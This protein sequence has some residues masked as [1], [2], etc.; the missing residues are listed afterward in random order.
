MRVPAAELRVQEPGLDGELR[1]V[2]RVDEVLELVRPLVEQDELADQV[3]RRRGAGDAGTL[4]VLRRQ[5]HEVAQRR[6]QV[7]AHDGGQVPQLLVARAPGRDVAEQ[8]AQHVVDVAHCRH[9]AD[10]QAAAV[11]VRLA[12]DVGQLGLQLLRLR[13]DIRLGR[14]RAGRLSRR[15]GFGDGRTPSEEHA[16]LLPHGWGLFGDNASTTTRSGRGATDQPSVARARSR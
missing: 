6:R 15:W 16:G 12:D 9:R 1:R 2:A 10:R 5:G 14:L 8:R 4:R 13:R 7:L 11:P 3:D